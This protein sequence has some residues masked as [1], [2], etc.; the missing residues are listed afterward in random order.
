MFILGTV[1]F[2]HSSSDTSLPQVSL[3]GAHVTENIA[4]SE[5]QRGTRSGST[6][7]RLQF[8][9][10]LNKKVVYSQVMARRIT[11]LTSVKGTGCTNTDCV[12][13]RGGARGAEAQ[14]KTFSLQVSLKSDTH[15]EPQAT[16][17]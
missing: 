3:T 4:P 12:W 2:T 16:H 14:S 15:L 10:R 7:I 8:K 1:L 11:Q 17:E 6:T 9:K 13:D 5:G